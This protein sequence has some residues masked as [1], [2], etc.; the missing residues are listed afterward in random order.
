MSSD[1]IAARAESISFASLQ[2]DAG[3]R[4]GLVVMGAQAGDTTLWPTGNQGLV[5]L[6]RDGLQATAGLAQDLLDTG[7]HPATGDPAPAG[8]V[9]WQEAEP[10][11]FQVSRSWQT[12]NGGVARQRARGQLSCG[13]P[14][15]REMPLTRLAL[16]RCEQQL[17]WEDGRVTSATL[18][19]DAE[20]LR[21]WAVAETPWP[22]GPR[23]EWEVARPWW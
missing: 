10:G 17:T 6:Y 15:L 22:D 20:T 16:Q 13:V 21:L 14:E 23:I 3:D 19:R 8:Y 2:L 18:W 7:Y 9:P 11:A 12:P 1:A 4:R 5:A